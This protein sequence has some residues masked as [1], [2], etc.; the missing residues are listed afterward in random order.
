[1]EVQFV[2]WVKFELILLYISELLDFVMEKYSVLW[3]EYERNI[4]K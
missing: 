3:V 2:L 4:F 1:M